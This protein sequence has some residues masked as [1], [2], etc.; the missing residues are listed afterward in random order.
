VRIAPVHGGPPTYEPLPVHAPASWLLSVGW[1]MYGLIDP[2][3]VPSAL[4][5]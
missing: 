5:R 4:R 3:V 2:R 1:R